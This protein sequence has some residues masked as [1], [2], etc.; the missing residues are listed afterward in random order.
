[1]NVPLCVHAE[2]RANSLQNAFSCT[3][4]GLPIHHHNDIWDLTATLMEEVSSLTEIEPH[5]Q[6]LTSEVLQG[7]SVKAD[8]SSVSWTF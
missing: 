3:R 1:M 6:P 5:L 2:I 8:Q 7:R 4:E